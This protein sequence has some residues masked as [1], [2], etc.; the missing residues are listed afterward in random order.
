MPAPPFSSP[1][2]AT[3]VGVVALTVVVFAAVVAFVTVRLRRG[4]QEQVLLGHAETLSAVASLQLGNEAERVG[5]SNAPGALFKAVSSA[6]KFRDVIAVRVFD[7]A[8]KIDG[9]LPWLWSEEPPPA[10]VWSELMA[11]RAVTRL[12]TRDA[13][14]ELMNLGIAQSGAADVPLIEAWVPLRDSARGRISGAAQFWSEGASL[15]GQFS[16]IDERLIA[17]A[18]L[19]WLAG[20]LVITAVLAWAF[21]RLAAANRELRLH[22]ENLQRAN[23]ELVLAAKSSALGSITAHLIHALKNPIAGLEIFVASQGDTS[24]RTEGGEE[25]AAAT[26]LTRRLRTMV[27]DVVE[28]L[29]DEASGTQFEL[30]G[31]DMVELALAKARPVAEARGVRLLA[32]ITSTTLL[33]ARRASLAALALYNLLQN[34]IEATATGRT[35][36]IGARTPAAGLEFTVTD[37]GAGLPAAV[38]ERLFQPCTSTK[39]GGSGLGLALSQQLARHAGGRIEL[40]RSDEQGTSFRLVLDP[41]P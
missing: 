8:E 5:M 37:E 35:V 10:T 40:L 23:R 17:Q 39:L 18:V 25:L 2:R 24:T 27:N 20:A 41:E 22:S 34:A 1:D 30:S 4:L 21:R 16:A 32:D 9:G 7:A 3:R 15:A 38:R 11:G 33:P 26:E 12:H 29:R 36:R 6:A 13:S 14:L 31:N 19:A 28:V